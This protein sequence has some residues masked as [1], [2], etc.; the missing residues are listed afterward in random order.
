MRERKGAV[1]LEVSVP[2]HCELMRNAADELEERLKSIEFKNPKI[3]V[4]QNVDGEIQTALEIQ[5]SNLSNNFIC[6]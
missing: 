3:D 1:P 2:S 4:V 6:Q 5:K